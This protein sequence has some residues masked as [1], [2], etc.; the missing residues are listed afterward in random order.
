MEPGCL[1]EGVV[2]QSTLDTDIVG[3]DFSQSVD[4]RIRSVQQVRYQMVL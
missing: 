2:K 4:T 3:T 1:T